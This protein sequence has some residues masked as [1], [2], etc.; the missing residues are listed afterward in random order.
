MGRFAQSAP[1]LHLTR[2]AEQS[3]PPQTLTGTLA[4]HPATL[5]ANTYMAIAVAPQDHEPKWREGGDIPADLRGR[6]RPPRHLAVQSPGRGAKEQK[7]RQPGPEY[8]L[9]RISTRHRFR[10]RYPAQNISTI[11][12]PQSTVTASNDGLVGCTSPELVVLASPRSIRCLYCYKD[13]RCL[14]KSAMAVAWY[15]VQRQCRPNLDDMIL[16]NI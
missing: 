1:H 3:A 10:F 16:S 7:R 6:S 15:L 5:D 4:A 8:L 11:Q 14:T 13:F 2:A 12:Q 9:H